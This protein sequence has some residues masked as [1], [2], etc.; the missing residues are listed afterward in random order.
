MNEAFHRCK[1]CGQPLPPAKSPREAPLLFGPHVLKETDDGPIYP[2]PAPLYERLSWYQ[3]SAQELA[4]LRAMVEHCMSGQTLWV[5]IPRLA[6]YSKLDE[7]DIRTILHGRKGRER[8]I[9]RSGK[10]LRWRERDK[11]GLIARRIL[12]EVAPHS[13]SRNLPTTYRLN[14]AVL[15]WDKRMKEILLADCQLRLPGVHRPAIPGEA[16]VPNFPT[17]F[18][19]PVSDTRPSLSLPPGANAPGGGAELDSPWVERPRRAGSNAPGGLGRTPPEA[20]SNAPS[21]YLLH[22]PSTSSI[23]SSSSDDELETEAVARI[24]RKFVSSIDQQAVDKIIEG[25][26]VAA[27]A[28]G[29]Q[30]AR[31]RTDELEHFTRELLRRG[32]NIENPVGFLIARLPGCFEGEAYRQA[33]A[34][35]AATRAAKEAAEAKREQLQAE[36]DAWLEQWS[37]DHPNEDTIPMQDIPAHLRTIAEARE[38]GAD[39]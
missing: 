18:A 23:S 2:P 39:T 25:C 3:L 27:L 31:A 37:R 35:L 21:E 19:A 26:R 6:A 13:S 22:N 32:R 12:T 10:E 29:A 28:S 16:V 8:T 34:D 36:L 11:T 4:V 15:R 1:S 5:S 7:R 14:E 24:L 33:K 17:A 38:Q 9:T 20:G 30:P